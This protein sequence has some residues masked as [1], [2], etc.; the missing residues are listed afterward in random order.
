MGGNLNRSK[1]S[2]S[3]LGVEKML[4]GACLG[5]NEGLKNM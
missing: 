1:Q 4:K 3:V 5:D 2:Y